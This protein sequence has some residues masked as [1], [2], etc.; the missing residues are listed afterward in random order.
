[1][2]PEHFK[3]FKDYAP[4]FGVVYDEN[5]DSTKVVA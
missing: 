2:A 5:Y 3:H 1:M 4:K